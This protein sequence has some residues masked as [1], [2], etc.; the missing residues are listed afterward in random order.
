MYKRREGKEKKKKMDHV[1]KAYIH[2]FQ[3]TISSHDS[4]CTNQINVG[5]YN[6]DKQTTFTKS[7]RTRSS[8]YL[9]LINRNHASI[10]LDFS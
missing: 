7:I 10:H 3:K 5:E 1:E 6:Q 8:H 2:F 4:H 9:Q